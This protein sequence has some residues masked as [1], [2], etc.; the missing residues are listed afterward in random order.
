MV[1]RVNEN[2]LG[3]KEAAALFGVRPSNFVRDW[4][5][6]DDFPGPVATL[7]RGRLWA[8]EDLISYRAR[9]GPR[10]A[11]ALA[12][13]P[14]SP[15]AARWLPV[16][17]RRIV[18]RFRPDRIVLFGSQ[19]RGDARLDSDADLL[20]VIPGNAHRRHTEAAIYGS[21]AGIP[22]GTDVVVVH[23]EDITRGA[24]L[25]GTILG[26]VLREGRTVYVRS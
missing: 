18:R 1:E 9:T 19:V 4:A 16:I 12:E 25:V 21:L 17:K 20:V 8:R 15:D 14:L 7:A 26:P 3:T 2:L 5:S 6:R 22:L 13:L 11:V 23:P 10:R 24:D